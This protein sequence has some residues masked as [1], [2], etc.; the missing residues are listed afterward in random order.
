MKLKSD[1]QFQLEE[2]HHCLCVRVCMCICVCACAC[3]CAYAC[4]RVRVHALRS[5]QLH[6]TVRLWTVARQ[7]LQSIEFSRQKHWSGLPFPLPGDL[8]HSG[9]EP[10]SPVSP[11]LQ[12]DSLPS[13]PLGKPRHCLSLF[14][15][16]KKF[17]IIWLLIPTFPNVSQLSLQSNQ[18]VLQSVKFKIY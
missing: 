10:V 13:E 7:A 17:V 8:P 15:L 12:A 1:V 16:S 11:A 14:Q 4:A 6:L 2:L 3:V 9:M 18:E 5:L